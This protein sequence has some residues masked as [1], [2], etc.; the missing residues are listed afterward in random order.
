LPFFRPTL[1][2]LQDDSRVWKSRHQRKA[3]NHV[4]P[5]HATRSKLGRLFVVEYWNISWWIAMLFTIGSIVWVINGF[6]AFL[7][8]CNSHVQMNVTAIGWTAWLGATIFA[9]AAS[10][11]VWEA[12][13]RGESAYFGGSF[14]QAIHHGVI[15]RNDKGVT[16][17]SSQKTTGHPQ[18][19][20]WFTTDTR[21]WHE[22]G[23]VAGVIQ[24]CGAL[25]FW[26]SGFTGL[27]EIQASIKENTPL[28]D[29]IFWSP[30]VIG[31]SGFIISSILYMLESQKRWYVP[32]LGELGWHVGFWNFVGGVGFT[33]CGAF[34]YSTAHWAQYQST[35][36]TFWGGFAFLI[37]SVMQLY[38]AVNPAGG[39]N[40]AA[41]TTDK[42]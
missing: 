7:P 19:W 33:I 3:R 21:Y 18:G 16:T 9:I 32:A 1:A 22:I 26:I 27:P 40:D 25:I 17:I 34:G 42:A 37:G 24:C 39:M 28:L 11:P 41:E 2:H 12:W 4:V 29:G 35:L 15:L 8:F 38:E 36:S 6:F 13:N 20:I 14:D 10:L 5:S 31:G 30:Q 23:F